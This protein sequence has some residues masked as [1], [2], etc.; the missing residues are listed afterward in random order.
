MA[1]NNIVVQGLCKRLEDFLLDNFQGLQAFHGWYTQYHRTA[2]YHIGG[3][4]W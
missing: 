3:T 1:D 4:V 2:R